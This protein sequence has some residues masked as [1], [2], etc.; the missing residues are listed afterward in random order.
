[1]QRSQSHLSQ[2]FEHFSRLLRLV[3]PQ[4]PLDLP[5]PRHP[6]HIRAV[7]GSPQHPRKLVRPEHQ[8]GKQELP[9]GPLALRRRALFPRPSPPGQFAFEIETSLPAQLGPHHSRRGLVCGVG[10][11]G[12]G[13]GVF[14]TCRR[15]ITLNLQRAENETVAGGNCSGVTSAAQR[16]CLR[17][18]VLPLQPSVHCL[19][20]LHPF[21]SRRAAAS[22]SQ[23]D[24]VSPLGQRVTEET[25]DATEVSRL[26]NRLFRR[27]KW[28]DSFH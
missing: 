17:A 23:S 16:A 21:A 14:T 25:P 5:D 28:M 6:P 19:M 8:G 26:K 24:R 4:K 13:D 3:L 2:Q 15:I 18:L 20:L 11:V 22:L 10:G 7:V 12:V 9:A 1:M 27:K